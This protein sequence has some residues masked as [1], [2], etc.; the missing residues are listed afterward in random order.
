MDGARVA[1]TMLAMTDHVLETMRELH[2]R[3]SDGIDVRLLWCE[4]DNR[5]AVRVAD[6]KTGDAFAV[7][8]GPRDRALD[9]FHHPYAY[10]A[11]R[12]IDTRA[13]IAA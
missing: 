13:L 1:W 7:E 9:V 5:V 4:A 2:R 12:G 10:A 11:A 8:V 3:R 6:A